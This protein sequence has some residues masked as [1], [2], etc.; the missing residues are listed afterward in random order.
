MR[1]DA[2]RDALKDIPPLDVLRW[3]LRGVDDTKTALDVL[4]EIKSL[5]VDILEGGGLSHHPYGSWVTRDLKHLGVSRGDALFALHGQFDDLCADDR[6]NLAIH[7]LCML[8][9]LII[10]LNTKMHGRPHG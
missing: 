3:A 9:A 4:Y 10:E 2:A 6:V 5:L 7:A 1:Q 8:G